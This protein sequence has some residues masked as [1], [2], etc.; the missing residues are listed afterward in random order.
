MKSNRDNRSKYIAMPNQKLLLIIVIASLQVCSL[1][2]RSLRISRQPVVV[3]RPGQDPANEVT[4]PSSGTLKTSQCSPDQSQMDYYNRL[5][6]NGNNGNNLYYALKAVETH[7]NRTGAAITEDENDVIES[8]EQ[9]R[10][11]PAGMDRANKVV[12]AKLLQEMDAETSLFSST[13]LCAWDYICDYK[14]DRFPNYLFKARCKTERCNGD[15]NKDK[16]NMCQSH[17]IH[18]TVLEMRGNCGEWVWGQELLPIAC[19]CTVKT[20]V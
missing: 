12:C 17:G 2:A 15:C 7:K 16:H 8:I 19:T 6:I 11:S 5:D 13:A 9:S 4:T 14:A 18:V 1:Y 3:S 10:F 20:G